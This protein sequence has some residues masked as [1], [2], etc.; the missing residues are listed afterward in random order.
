[1]DKKKRSL[2]TTHN[3][4]NTSNSSS[5]PKKRRRR[6]AASDAS[7]KV[8]NICQMDYN[9][10]DKANSSPSDKIPYN[11]PTKK[12]GVSELVVGRDE[13]ISTSSVT[14]DTF[15]P[16]GKVEERWFKNF[17]KWNNSNNSN[18]S[19][20]SSSPIP[21]RWEQEQRAQYRLYQQNKKTQ[22]TH[23]RATLLESGGFCWE[24]S[25]GKRRAESNNEDLA[26]VKNTAINQQ[27]S[28]PSTK[29]VP[30]SP[31][32]RK[33]PR[34]SPP[35]QFYHNL[36]KNS[37]SKAASNS[38][39][40]DKMQPQKLALAS[41]GKPSS[42]SSKSPSKRA[43]SNTSNSLVSL[44]A[45]AN[46]FEKQKKK[47]KRRGRHSTSS[48]FSLEST[49]PQQV[50]TVTK[51]APTDTNTNK[52]KEK[53]KSFS[54]EELQQE[55]SKKIKKKRKPAKKKSSDVEAAATAAAAAAAGGDG[56]R[57]NKATEKT[58]SVD[59]KESTDNNT[60]NRSESTVDADKKS[61]STTVTTEEDA[62]QKSEASTVDKS[63]NSTSAAP[64]PHSPLR[65]T[66]LLPTLDD[67]KSQAKNSAEVAANAV[68]NNDKEEEEV[69]VTKLLLSCLSE[70]S[71]DKQQAQ[72]AATK[73][74]VA[75]D[76]DGTNISN[77][78]PSTTQE[79]TKSV[80]DSS[81]EVGTI[82]AGITKD[83]P[84]LGP[85][86]QVNIVPRK[87][88]DRSDSYYLSPTG[89]RFN[90]MKRAKAHASAE[91]EEEGVDNN[92]SIEVD[93]TQ[94]AP[95]ASHVNEQESA[96]GE[97][98]EQQ[99]TLQQQIESADKEN[100]EQSST[101]QLQAEETAVEEDNQHDHSSDPW[102]CDICQV[103]KFDD[104]DDAVA[105]EKECIKT[106]NTQESE[107]SSSNENVEGAS[108]KEVFPINDH[109]PNVEE[110]EEQVGH[111]ESPKSLSQS[112]CAE[113]DNNLS[114]P[115]SAPE[116][117]KSDYRSTAS[118]DGRQKGS[119]TCDV[120]KV[121]TFEYYDEAVAH[122]ENCTADQRENRLS[123]ANNE[124]KSSEKSIDNNQLVLVQNGGSVAVEESTLPLF[125]P[126]SFTSPLEKGN[127]LTL[128]STSIALQPHQN[129][130][131]VTESQLQMVLAEKEYQNRMSE[132]G[133]LELEAKIVTARMREIENRI[134]GLDSTN[135]TSNNN[136][137]SMEVN[138]ESY[139]R[140]RSYHSQSKSSRSMHKSSRS[141]SHHYESSE[142]EEERYHDD[143]ISPRKRKQT[144][145]SE[146]GME[147]RFYPSYSDD[148]ESKRSKKRPKEK[149]FNRHEKSRK[150]RS[151]H[152]DYDYDDE[153]EVQ[154]LATSTRSSDRHRS[155]RARS[156][157]QY[158]NS[159]Y[160]SP[161]TRKK[162]LKDDKTPA[163]EE[164]H[165]VALESRKKSRPKYKQ[166]KRLH[167]KPSSEEELPQKTRAHKAKPYSEE[168]PQPHY[169]KALVEQHKVLN[170]C[171]NG[172][173][174]HS[175]KE[176]D[177][178]KGSM[179]LQSAEVNEEINN[180]GAKD[181]KN[182]NGGAH[183]QANNEANNPLYWLAGNE[184]SSDDES[185]DFDG[186]MILPPPPV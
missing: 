108:S 119:W 85:G 58:K 136:V 111:E 161:S 107:P 185:W 69:C 116:K 173:G 93:E 1:M 57:A 99:S 74:G 52:N 91:E 155:E 88:G 170:D 60:G 97:N 138:E 178:Q 8:R 113:E 150:N 31:S 68:N 184:H 56:G 9:D 129:E 132:Y 133:R 64:S 62:N 13:T 102:I 10:N 105:H 144:H 92:K 101:L 104:Y 67:G 163:F 160:N 71:A 146:P 75:R 128:V 11:K 70:D 127:D 45:D 53:V 131:R 149:P 65:V 87:S 30:D 125:S 175:T 96:N 76:D 122:E 59:E 135:T 120:C 73:S 78:K 34:K 46:K 147:S 130:T 40:S 83:V 124:S 166:K 47:K 143:Y 20:A 2:D 100:L 98:P 72:G 49:T 21:N 7:D 81:S 3:S 29:D 36:E 186:D 174:A 141:W 51:N 121:A 162:R 26:D 115:P 44:S 117:E 32:K 118:T 54:H 12:K 123:S 158:D 77:T 17:K 94:T 55:L 180:C 152:H 86:W 25:V 168:E 28:A 18:A 39:K 114:K 172:V 79:N 110:S 63:S 66:R 165:Q 153:S 84:K 43:L 103:E 106:Y 156:P 159:K 5:Q 50:D 157:K 37:E 140:K 22:M 27:P 167:H 134:K 179:V 23:Y 109:S 15:I 14:I 164:T 148:H 24:T 145:M 181:D 80:L 38:P 90:S 154:A 139:S 41:S 82:K 171:D 61:L 19:A 126:L 182:G 33:S 142:E 4:N 95:P 151:S 6:K 16:K 169:S 183:Q 42:P 177:G 137:A 48:L 112:L 35:T 176:D 89:Q